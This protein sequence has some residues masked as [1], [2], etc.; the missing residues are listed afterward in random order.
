MLYPDKELAVNEILDNAIAGQE[1]LIDV[2]DGYGV[3]HGMWMVDNMETIE[4]LQKAMADKTLYV[5]DGHHRYAT[6][7]NYWKERAEAGVRTRRL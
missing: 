5:A 3:G 1:P 2:Q 4:Q 6:A 7:V